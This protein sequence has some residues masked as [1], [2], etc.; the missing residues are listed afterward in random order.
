MNPV[1]FNSR[2]GAVTNF[3]SRASLV[4][5][6]KSR[7]APRGI[8]TVYVSAGSSFS[9]G[10][11][12]ALSP[13]SVAR[14]A[15]RFPSESDISMSPNPGPRI[16]GEENPISTGVSRLTSYSIGDIL[17]ISICS[18]FEPVV[19]FTSNAASGLSDKSQTEFPGIATVYWAAGSNA[20]TGSTVIP[21]LS[22]CTNTLAGTPAPL[23]S[24]RAIRLL[25]AFTCSEKRMST[26]W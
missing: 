11:K 22:L 7:Y 23:L 21:C 16:T 18:K 25:S 19:K 26:D 3:I 8:F 9:S 13:A 10:T 6:L 15:I 14:K 4:L 24:K 5:L 17:A 2:A 1:S 12:T 20:F